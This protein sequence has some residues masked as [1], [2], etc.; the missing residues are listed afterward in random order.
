MSIIKDPSRVEK[1]SNTLILYDK[2]T[3]KEVGRTELI[4][5]KCWNFELKKLADFCEK[6]I[7]IRS[8]DLRSFDVYSLESCELLC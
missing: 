6:C 7:F 2:K 8:D 1:I 3:L 5:L 4:S